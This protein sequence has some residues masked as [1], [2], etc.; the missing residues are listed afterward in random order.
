MV[1]IFNVEGGKVVDY[2]K[3]QNIRNMTT[4]DEVDYSGNTVTIHTSAEKLYYEEKLDSVV[5]GYMT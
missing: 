1:N 2:G 3:Y 4:T 5:M